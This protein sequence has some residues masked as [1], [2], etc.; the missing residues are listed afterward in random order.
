VRTGQPLR[1]TRTLLLT[2]LLAGGPGGPALIAQPSPIQEFVRQEHQHGVPYGEAR[3]YPGSAAP[4]LL[5]MLADPAES[6]WWVN[7]VAVLGIIGDASVAV[8]LIEFAR[9]GSGPLTPDA[10]RAKSTVLLALGYLVNHTGSRVALDYLLKSANPEAWHT[11]ALQWSSPFHATP[12]ERNARL[13]ST[14]LLGLALSGAPEAGALLRSLS[15]GA[16]RTSLAPA[17][18]A[19]IRPTARQALPEFRL[20]ARLGLARYYARPEGRQEPRK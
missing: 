4:V 8:P 13:S 9:Q 3:R 16:D 19:R 12:A 11:R 5:G 17:H 2:G 10:Y 14:A 15:T 20:I 6:P 18:A 7:V 1:V